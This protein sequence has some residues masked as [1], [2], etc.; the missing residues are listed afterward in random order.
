MLSCDYCQDWFHY[1]CVGLRAPSDDEDDEE[2]APEDYCCP[3][4]CA[5]VQ[6]QAKWELCGVNMNCCNFNQ[7]LS[8]DTWCILTMRETAEGVN[9]NVV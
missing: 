4:C 6:L 1:D 9:G 5:K 7:D 8:C 2:V 3:N